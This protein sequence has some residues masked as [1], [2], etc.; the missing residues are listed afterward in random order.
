MGCTVIRDQ[1]RCGA[2]QRGRT[3][4]A[5]LGAVVRRGPPGD[6]KLLAVAWEEQVLQYLLRAEGSSPILQWQW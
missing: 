1:R 5:V 6:Q 3:L 4:C 2:C